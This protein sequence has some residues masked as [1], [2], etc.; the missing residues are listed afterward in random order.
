MMYL[1]VSSTPTVLNRSVRSRLPAV[2]F[3]PFATISP[4]LT[5]ISSTGSTKYSVASS[6]RSVGI[7]IIFLSSPLFTMLTT[8]VISDIKE[9]NFGALASTNSSTLGKP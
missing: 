3:S 6:S 1:L 7:T 8:P 5:I 4:S 9:R 2:N